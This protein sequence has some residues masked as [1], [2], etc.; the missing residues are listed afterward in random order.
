MRPLLVSSALLTTW[1]C[2]P[3]HA[4]AAQAAPRPP[5]VPS[6]YVP[7]YTPTYPPGRF[8]TPPPGEPDAPRPVIERAD[9]PSPVAGETSI[10]ARYRNQRPR[11]GHLPMGWL[12]P[13]GVNV[14]GVLRADEGKSGFLI[15]A[16]ASV[17]KFPVKDGFWAGGYTDALYDHAQEQVRFSAG[18][19]LGWAMLGLDAGV[20][21][22]LGNHGSGWGVM[23]RGFLTAGILTAYVRYGVPVVHQER[24]PR[25]VEI[26]ALFKIPVTLKD[27]D[28]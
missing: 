27:L 12:M 3:G 2:L 19:E 10:P 13:I 26:G 28:D 18:P 23:A 1:L 5:E 16:E 6:P 22:S 11:R 21:G 17:V 4:H 7:P 9:E 20:F 14:G 15:G 24:D 8:A 25:F